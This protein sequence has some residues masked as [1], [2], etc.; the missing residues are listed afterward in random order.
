MPK[1]LEYTAKTLTPTYGEFFAQPFEKGW[2]TTI[3][4]AL[5]R[6]LLSSVEGAAISALRIEGVLHEF[7]SIPGVYEDVTDIILNLKQLPVALHSDAPQMITLDIKGPRKIT[8]GDIVCPAE[9]EV[10]DKSMP[11][12]TINEEGSLRM[13]MM[14]RRGR[15]YSPAEQNFDAALDKG[16]IPI[17][18]IYSPVKKVRYF[19]ENSRLGQSTDY[20]KLT[21]E[22][23][24]NGVVTPADA[25]AEAAQLLKDHLLLFLN[26]E[27][28]E[29]EKPAAAAAPED[30]NLSDFD[31]LLLT[32]IEELDLSVRA[33]N[34]LKNAEIRNLKDLVV[35]TEDDLLKTK[36][37]GQKTLKEIKAL[38]AEKDLSLGMTL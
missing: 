14:V 21:L 6:V 20:D 31:R 38:L 28:G 9:V 16:F 32:P 27:V 1:R 15:G 19:V 26:F 37:F 29:E 24:T 2:G 22:L 11:I 33:Y 25:L 18:A 5:R 36:N 7:T 35:K 23:W 34:C 10:L 12:C 13:E 3:G 17:D 4:N 8:A 30:A